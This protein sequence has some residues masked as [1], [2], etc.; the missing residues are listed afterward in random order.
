PANPSWWSRY[1]ATPQLRKWSLLP[2]SS[3]DHG[4]VARWEHPELRSAM[5]IDTGSW[6][7][8]PL[9]VEQIG[10]PHVVE[11]EYPS[12]MAQSLGIS[13]L[14][15]NAAGEL[16]P[17]G[18]DSGVYNETPAK[19]EPAKW[20]KHRIVFWPRSK[21]PL[22]LL[23]N[24]HD[25]RPAVHG[26]IRVLAGP[27]H[28]PTSRRPGEL[29]PE[30]LLAGY[31]ERP[32][33][34]ENFSASEAYDSFSRRSLDDWVTYFEASTRLAEYLDHVGYGGVMAAVASEGSTIYPSR[35]LE[36]TPRSDTGVFLST[37]GDPFRKDGLELL[38][39]VFDH[40]SL[41]LIPAVQFSTPLPALEALLDRHPEAAAGIVPIG[42]D[43]LPVSTVEAIAIGGGAYYN[44][45][46]ERVQKAMLDVIAELVERYGE[47]P[48]LGGVAVQLSTNGYGVLPGV[49][50]SLDDATW[51][52]YERDT[53]QSLAAQGPDRFARRGT[54]VAGQQRAEWLKWRADRLALFQRRA[55][56]IVARAGKDLRL[57][58]SAVG[59]WDS[60]D[61]RE[62]L[63]PSLTRATRVD[64]MLLSVGI[65]VD[66]YRRPD[67]AG[68]VFLRPNRF[69]PPS[70]LDRHAAD[71]ALNQSWELDRSL[72]AAGPVASVFYHPPS[73]LRLPSFDE[74]SPVGRQ[75]TYVWLAAQMSPSGVE[76]R[77]RFV[78]ALA[79]G[80]ATAMFD[81][82]WMM[83]LGQEDS[84]RDLIDVY[85]RL[86]AGRFETV[87]DTPRPVTIRL[88]SKH[89]R[90]LAYVV[91][92]SP[93]RVALDVEVAASPRCRAFSLSPQRS[94]PELE[95]VGGTLR[96]RMTL[97]P[98]DA[99]A[100][101]FT[102][103]G[104]ALSNPTVDIDA[105]V[106]ESLRR[107]VEQ[108]GQRAQRLAK[109]PTYDK[110][111]NP[112][113]ETPADVGQ[114]PAWTA[115]VQPGTAVTLGGAAAEGSQ[116]A[117]MTSAGRAAWLVSD[118]LDVP[119]SGRL[120]VL[121]RLRTADAVRQPPLSVAL[122]ISDG[123]ASYRLTPIAVGAAPANVPL[124]AAWA[125]YLFPFDDLP[126]TPG[127]KVRVQ[128]NLAGAGEV[129]IDDVRLLHLSLTREEHTGLG[130]I[131]SLAN[132]YVRDGQ[133]ADCAAVLEGYWPRFVEENVPLDE[134][135]EA[136]LERPAAATD[137]GDA[138]G[139]KT[140][141]RILDRLNLK[142]LKSY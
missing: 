88:R 44:P 53:G 126:T 70:T 45:L 127:A 110:L 73:R 55:A 69:G 42:P 105:V 91:N 92:D 78:H 62:R 90:T 35:M 24:R 119:K 27:A 107:R 67:M 8:L 76:N 21:T 13:I 38:L 75:K 33:L 4:N 37:G 31:L 49:Q 86:P 40:R 52:T 116:A 142:R 109:S 2:K 54:A 29:R 118:E 77:R 61:V 94:L 139:E 87:E 120:A 85:R 34:A 14:D 58:V 81:G 95:N 9:P 89:R 104:V 72:F 65:D 18:L 97:E 30:R 11:V 36:P 133:W 132:L 100:A 102:E 135:L 22:I 140:S 103:P 64:E 125:E 46:D 114:I 71:L 3:W 124:T 7:A 57:Y 108:L 74:K 96:W 130:K 122:E 56:A 128:F 115:S 117:T 131:V 47:H 113:F 112:G 48:S 84:L 15:P 83:P 98:Y 63:R 16:V 26:K 129:R 80:D 59:V 43:G 39:R 121:V 99:V 17:V 79:T 60:P 136:R 111:A 141:E 20:L 51:A 66:A 68:V 19:D 12:D 10:M 106:S 32:L 1:I 123:R 6:E 50:W 137:G 23:V 25:S 101:V 93:W 138:G 41:T 134:H 82:G 28:L 5:R